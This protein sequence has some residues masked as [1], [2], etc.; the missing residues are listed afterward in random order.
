MKYTKLA[1]SLFNIGVFK[2]KSQSTEGKGFKL[3]LHETN[4]DAPLSPFYLDLRKIQS[5]PPT[6]ILTVK[7]LKIKLEEMGVIDKLGLIKRLLWLLAGIPEAA[8]PM[9]ACLSISTDIPMI[10]PRELKD[11]G[12]QAKIDGHYEAGQK[13][14]LIDDLITRADSKFEKIKILEEAGLIVEHV[15]VVVDRDQGGSEDIIEAGY[16]FHSIFKFNDLLELYLRESLISRDVYREIHDY[17]N[18]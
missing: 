7:A 14:V 9:T 1:R 16:K 18:K 10:T 4:P 5:F 11:R 6:M 2:D 13:V 17:L 3:K 12:T 8:T 15:L